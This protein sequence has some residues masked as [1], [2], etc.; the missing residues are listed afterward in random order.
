MASPVSLVHLEPRLE[1]PFT[2][3][4]AKPWLRAAADPCYWGEVLIEQQQFVE[5]PGV[6]QVTEAGATSARQ[7]SVMLRLLSRGKSSI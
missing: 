1:V 5:L 3:R 7:Q 4:P 6:I 2:G